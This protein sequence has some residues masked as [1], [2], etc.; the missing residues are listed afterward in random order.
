M[1]IQ[2]I[3]KLVWGCKT[4]EIAVTAPGYSLTWDWWLNNV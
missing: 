3:V 1:V 4:P 2:G